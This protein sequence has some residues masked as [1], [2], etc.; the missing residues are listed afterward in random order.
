MDAIGK[1]EELDSK[2]RFKSTIIVRHAK[3]FS[4]ESFRKNL[5]SVIDESLAEKG[6]SR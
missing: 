6:L 4:E 1:F 2:E 3:N 5:L